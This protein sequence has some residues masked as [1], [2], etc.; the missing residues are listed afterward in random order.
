MRLIGKDITGD[1]IPDIPLFY[2]LDNSKLSVK[3]PLGFCPRPNV[4]GGILKNDTICPGRF[5]IVLKEWDTITRVYPSTSSYLNKVTKQFDIDVMDEDGNKL[6]VED[7]DLDIELVIDRMAKKDPSAVSYSKA[8]FEVDVTSRLD[9]LKMR[10]K[11]PLIYHAFNIT[12]K[13]STLTIQIRQI[14]DTGHSL[15]KN[16]S[17][18]AILLRYKKMPIFNNCEMVQQVSNI[19]LTQD[20]HLDWFLGNDI[21][22]SRTGNWYLAVA[23]LEKKLEKDEGTCDHLTKGDLSWDFNTPHYHLQIYIGGGYYFD[24]NS[25]DWDGKG[26]SVRL[27]PLLSYIHN[28][29]VLFYS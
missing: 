4:P 7:L 10:N 22:Q 20:N 14:D 8:G 24:E 9:V 11:P 29:T 27:I 13:F 28:L 18:L 23:S 6:I 12:N 25:D 3:F 21:I 26:T 19:N 16:E 15:P 1:L 5:G 17:T 2:E